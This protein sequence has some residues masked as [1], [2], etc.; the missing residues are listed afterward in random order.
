MIVGSWGDWPLCKLHARAKSN[1][2]QKL[3]C[4]E[5]ETPSRVNREGPYGEDGSGSLGDVTASGPAIRGWYSCSLSYPY[6][7]CV[8]QRSVCPFGPRPLRRSSTCDGVLY[9]KEV[10]DC[11]TNVAT[12]N[13]PQSSPG[14]L[15]LPAH[16]PPKPP[17]A[18]VGDMKQDRKVASPPT[19]C[20]I[21]RGRTFPPR[22]K[23]AENRW[24]SRFSQN[25]ALPHRRHGLAATK[26]RATRFAS[27][28]PQDL[29]AQLMFDLAKF[30]GRG[31]SRSL[32][33][34]FSVDRRGA[35]AARRRGCRTSACQDA[36]FRAHPGRAGCHATQ[37]LQ[38][39]RF[40]ASSARCADANCLRFAQRA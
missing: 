18:A 3:L 19:K 40:F 11:L 39:V 9:R 10:Q 23:S 30:R 33:L 4:G 27:S 36:G 15:P 6:A 2:G 28:L 22:G 16:A 20:H 37:A 7:R 21:V 14:P 25:R 26:I 38:V 34:E 1:H 5:Q 12:I 13:P 17:S 32:G 8:R 31:L 35:R 24:R 29:S